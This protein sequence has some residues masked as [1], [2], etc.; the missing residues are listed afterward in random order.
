MR[1]HYESRL[2]AAKTKARTARRQLHAAIAEIDLLT[3]RL[4]A[5][6]NRARNA[7]EGAAVVAEAEREIIPYVEAGISVAEIVEAA[8][9]DASDGETGD[10]RK[11]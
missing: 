6:F 7:L 9:G 11:D 4:T 5:D 1:K 2:K 3:A 8:K 10:Q